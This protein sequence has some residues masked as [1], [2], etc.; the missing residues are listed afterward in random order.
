VVGVSYRPPDQGEPTDKA[1]F[2]QLLEALSL[3]SLI[4]LEDF[5]HPEI[6]WKIIMA[7]CRQPR[8]FL[9]CIEDNSL[10]QVIDNL[11]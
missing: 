3:Q 5:N 7:S 11:T 6:C 10:S 1:F 8:R 9:E 4:L 2:L